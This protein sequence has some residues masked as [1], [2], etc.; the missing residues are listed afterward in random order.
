MPDFT[1]TIK[2]VVAI[3]IE[4]LCNG[5]E[6]DHNELNVRLS[7]ITSI[8]E[9]EE[10]FS[11]QDKQ[12]GESSIKNN[13]KIPNYIS[14]VIMI[15]N[16]MKS[17]GET[18]SE[19]SIIEKVLRYLTPRF[20][21]IIVAI[22]HSKDLSIMRIEE[23]QIS[24]EVQELHLTKRTSEREPNKERESEEENIARG[25][26]DDEP[27]LLM[28]YKSDDD[29]PVRLTFSDFEGDSEYESESEDDSESEEDEE[30]SEGKSDSEGESDSDPDSDDD[31]ESGGNQI[32]EGGAF[33][34]GPT[35]EGGQASDNVLES[36][37]D[38]KQV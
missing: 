7:A 26:Y 32:F 36:E 17:R 27:V 14:K 12:Y 23:L 30:D 29:E 4:I 21:Y 10:D 9:E 22:E 13:E 25:D 20:D 11:N 6:G 35:S 3:P 16:G 8:E 34:G 24:L 2:R 31:P 33:E 18:F 37:G 1:T 38:S 15:T 28:A 19:D 5:L